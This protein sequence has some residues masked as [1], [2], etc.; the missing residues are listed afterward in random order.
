MTATEQHTAVHNAVRG[1]AWTEFLLYANGWSVAEARLAVET[2]NDFLGR[3]VSAVEVQASAKYGHLKHVLARYEM[4]DPDRGP[5]D[6]YMSDAYRHN[7]RDSRFAY[8]FNPD[9]PLGELLEARIV[10]AVDRAL[11]LGL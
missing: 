10:S 4:P 11:G 1:E 2:Y 8:R 5:H 7:A 6:R 9:N 3:D